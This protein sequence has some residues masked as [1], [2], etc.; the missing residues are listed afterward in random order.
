M[1]ILMYEINLDNLNHYTPVISSEAVGFYKENCMVCFH[2]EGYK[3]G[4]QMTV[5]QGSTTHTLP[6]IWVG[7][8][9][10]Q[11]VR[12]YGDL[13]KAV[14]HAACALAL[15]IIHHLTDFSAIEQSAIGTT[16]DYFLG[17]KE[18]NDETLIFNHKARLEVSGI[19]K[20]NSSNTV[21]R[22][23]RSKLRRLSS[24][25]LPALIVVVEFSR[26]WSKMVRH[27]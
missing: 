13:S 5:V 27:E 20:E 8:V 24:S 17:L 2:H 25:D 19:L 18:N 12:S 16:I 3:S 10:E 9:T 4:L 14:D 26:P 15:S 21:D 6:V 7:S 11:M 22:R 23:I 1:G